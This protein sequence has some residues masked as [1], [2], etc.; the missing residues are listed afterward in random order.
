MESTVSD[1]DTPFPR[2]LRQIPPTTALDWELRRRVNSF[3]DILNKR[4]GPARSSPGIPGNL[5][6]YNLEQARSAREG[7]GIPH[8]V[9]RAPAAAPLKTKSMRA[10]GL[11][12]P[13]WRKGRMQRFES[14]VKIHNQPQEITSEPRIV[15]R[16]RKSR[17]G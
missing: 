9:L 14:G 1:N 12:I 6:K 10:A 11:R 4:R 8:Y 2:R 15:K 13:L 3:P 16:G 5:R 7:G 17:E